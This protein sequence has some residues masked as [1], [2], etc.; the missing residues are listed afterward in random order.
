[1]MGIMI[2][3]ITISLMLTASAEACE[4]RTIPDLVDIPLP[5][6]TLDHFNQPVSSVTCHK[7]MA[8]P[9]ASVFRCLAIHDTNLLRTVNGCYCYRNIRDT[10]RLSNHAHGTAIDIN[11]AGNEYGETPSQSPILVWCFKQ[12]GFLWGGDW[13]VPDGMHWE[14][15]RR[16][17]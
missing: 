9:L 1:M 2:S 15:P 6:G 16:N 13:N 8:A 4:S 14:L 5:T 17:K 3:L 10:G 12:A 11:A 7:S